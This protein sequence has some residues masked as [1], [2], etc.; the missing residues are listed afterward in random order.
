MCENGVTLPQSLLVGMT[1][2]TVPPFSQLYVSRIYAKPNFLSV[3]ISERWTLSTVG[4]F[5]GIVTK[6]FQSLTMSS[7]YPMV[8]GRLI[9]G[10]P[11]AINEI[12]GD[13]EISPDNGMLEGST[14]FC[15][16]PPGVSAFLNQE[17]EKTGNLNILTDNI[18]VSYTPDIKLAVTNKALVTSNND[19]TGS[20]DNCPTPIIKKINTVTPNIM[21]N[22][23]IYG[24]LPISIQIGADDARV[25]LTSELV[26]DQ[27]CPE[28]TPLT[29]PA[30]NSDVY[31]TDILT[32]TAP[33]WKG[34]TNL[35][36]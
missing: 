18:T 27:V 28:R 5:S 6:E 32:A 25:S 31:Y 9:V 13:N 4:V 21:G 20:L 7:V 34:W 35:P 29:P 33:E 3:I 36:T 23:D 17:I 2:T 12:L 16:N 1:V 22:I 11:E 19:L 14:I 26:L 10:D 30:N 15:F 24:I 8:G